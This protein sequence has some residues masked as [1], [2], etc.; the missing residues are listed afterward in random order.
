MRPFIFIFLLS[1]LVSCS[2]KKAPGDILPPDKM[3]QVL[4]EQMKADAFTK[5]FIARDSSKDPVKENLILQ[6]KIFQKYHTNRESFYK[7][8]EWYLAHDE[9][10]KD[11]LDSVI[12]KQGRNRERERTRKYLKLRNYEQSKKER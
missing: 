10:M 1:T 6:E 11:I 7:S 4:W 8:Y 9:Q 5:E 12:A 3:E 2:K